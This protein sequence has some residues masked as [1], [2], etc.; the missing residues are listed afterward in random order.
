MAWAFMPVKSCRTRILHALY[1]RMGHAGCSPVG[2]A[3][4]ST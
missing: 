2:V 4:A 1:E 3:I